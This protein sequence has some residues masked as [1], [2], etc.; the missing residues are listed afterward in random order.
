MELLCFLL[1]LISVLSVFSGA[2][3]KIPTTVDGPFDPITVPFDNSLRGHA[4]DLPDSDPRVGK[5]GRT[6]EPEQISL[7]LSTPDAIWVSYITGDFHIGNGTKRL[8]PSSVKSVVRY[9]PLRYPMAH[10]ATGYSLV[11]DQLYPF[12]GMQNY[13]S[14]IIHHVRL[15]GLKPGKRYYY[16]CGDSSNGPMSPIKSFRTMPEVR[17]KSYPGRIG[18]VG[19]LGLTYNTTSTVDHLRR[20]DPDLI[21]LVGDVTYANLY[22]TN[23]SGADC[24]ACAFPD[25]PI[26]ETYQPRWDYWGRFIEPLVSRVPM[27]VVEGNHEI[28]EQAFNKTFVA[29]SSRFAFP[30]EESGSKSTFYYSF[31]AGGIHFI[32]LSAYTSYYKSG[33]QYK[34]LQKDLEK[35]DRAVTPW[36]VVSWHPP[37]YSTYKAHYREAECMRVEME[38]LLYSYGVD[39]IFNGHVHAY[40]RSNRVYNYTLDPCGPIY[41]T[42]GDGG[43]R[44]KMSISHAD[45]KD[46]CPEPSSTPDPFMGGFC[47]ANFTAGPAAGKFCW[48]RQPEFSAYRESSFGHG[49]LEVK[50]ETY[51][52]WT[53]HRNQDMY[54]GIGDQIYIVRQPNKCPVHH[55]VIKPFRGPGSV[56]AK[57][58]FTSPHVW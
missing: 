5:R 35:V 36:L 15:T 9:G 8:D 58:L 54:N 43:N 38:E 4:I 21:L 27:M 31:D 16:R 32:M 12:E 55:K 56:A 44:E 37:W 14:G 28:E 17:D 23:G 53:W 18:V 2:I 20:N 49:I 24:Y 57:S 30:S 25:T 40:E 6:F 50:N 22:L 29:Y 48:D 45:D 47:A 10:E 7:S 19:D 1:A 26:H 13:S 3:A 46:G 39:I 51:A 34:W 11:Y 33:D 52:L 41:I 42:V